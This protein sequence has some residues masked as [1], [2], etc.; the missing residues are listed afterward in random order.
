MLCH[1]SRVV[2]FV[3][4]VY[5]KGYLPQHPRMIDSRTRRCMAQ[6]SIPDGHI[7]HGHSKVRVR[8]SVNKTNDRSEDNFRSL[9]MRK[10]GGPHVMVR[11]RGHLRPATWTET[12]SGKLRPSKSKGYTLTNASLYE[13]PPLTRKT[14]NCT[15]GDITPT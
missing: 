9:Q 2:M 4:I 14:R 10:V 12:F 5:A 11:K 6:A 8:L 13:S 7:N 3:W 15:L 1:H